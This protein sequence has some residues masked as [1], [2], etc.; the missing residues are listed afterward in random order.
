MLS[1]FIDPA[2]L[3]VLLYIITKGEAEADFGRVFFVSLGI[4]LGAAAIVAALGAALGLLALIPV[5]ALGVFMLMKFCYASLPQS[6][7]VLGIFAVY[8]IA[9]SILF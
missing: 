5:F 6:A 9:I 7:A 4:G 8:K 1:L 3:C 2:V